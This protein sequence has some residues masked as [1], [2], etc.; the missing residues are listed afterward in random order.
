MKI[1]KL[2]KEYYHLTKPGIIYGNTI[3]AAAGF[4]YAAKGN[5]DWPLLGATLLGLAC[6]IASGCV[7]NNYLDREIDVKMERTKL[8][9]LVVGSI[10]NQ[11][12]LIFSNILLLVGGLLLYYC[13]NL[14]ALSVA[15][16]GW[17]VYV[18]AYTPLKPKTALAVFVGAVAG[19]TPP[20]V[21]YAAVTNTLDLTALAMFAF[22][23]LWQLPHFLA[24]AK[25]RHHEYTAAGVPLLVK[26]PSSEKEAKQAKQIFYA[27][28]VV[29]LL[30]CF[31]LM[32][33]R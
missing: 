21:G 29:L 27:S 16:F 18:A 1:K 28:L 7:F 8:R 2:F 32:L 19:A 31:L 14:T 17:V 6:I 22:L 26:A 33:H 15:L 12:A 10:K 3:V 5:V 13:T 20:V 23:F 25:F 4:L 9:A 11:H 30:W 24:I